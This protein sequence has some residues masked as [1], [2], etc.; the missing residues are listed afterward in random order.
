MAA[1]RS[2]CWRLR[3]IALSFLRRC[4]NELHDFRLLIRDE[5]IVITISDILEVINWIEEHPVVGAAILVSIG[6]TVVGISKTIIQKLSKDPI[7]VNPT[8]WTLGR[9]FRIDSVHKY[10]PSNDTSGY[11]QYQHSRPDQWSSLIEVKSIL[12]LRHTVTPIDKNDVIVVLISRDGKETEKHI[13][14]N[15]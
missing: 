14:F 5:I 6:Y 13:Y 2:L 1:P 8:F 7:R 11:K 3:L 9:K 15:K 4:F 10:V 12:N